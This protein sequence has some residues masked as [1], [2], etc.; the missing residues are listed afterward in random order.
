MADYFVKD[1]K[2]VAR[3]TLEYLRK[4]Q[5]DPS[6]YMPMCILCR[7]NRSWVLLVHQV[8]GADQTMLFGLCEECWPREKGSELDRDTLNRIREKVVDTLQAE[9]R[10]IHIRPK[11]WIQ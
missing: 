2:A 3:I 10:T 4:L 11:E 6:K 5:K 8:E 9:E 7:K 1:T